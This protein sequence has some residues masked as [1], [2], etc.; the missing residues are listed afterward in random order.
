MNFFTV[1]SD[2]PGGHLRSS[3]DLWIFFAIA[4]PLTTIVLCFW[5]L[6]QWKEERE[7]NKR[8]RLA[9]M[10]DKDVEKS[11]AVVNSMISLRKT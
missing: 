7:A 11:G 4:V 5:W 3:K 10:L 2:S 8:K 6:W 9:G 1:D